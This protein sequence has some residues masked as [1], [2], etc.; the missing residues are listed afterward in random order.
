MSAHRVVEEN[1]T[2]VD[3]PEQVRLVSGTANLFRVLGV[4][5]LQGRGCR[6]EEDASG[7]APVAVITYEYWLRRFDA[8]PDILGR[9]LT[10]NG[11]PHTVVGVAGNIAQS[12][13]PFDG[14]VE[15]GLYLP[16]G[17]SPPRSF[18]LALR[19]DGKR[20]RLPRK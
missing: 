9:T 12:R 8:D 17:Q 2:G 3:Q 20:G 11:V 16:A 7:A 18:A 10:L 1:V 14:M 5:P 19:A 13:I 4:E 15:P 6:P